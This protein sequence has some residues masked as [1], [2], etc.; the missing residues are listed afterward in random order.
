VNLQ[1]LEVVGEEELLDIHP[2]EWL[3]SPFKDVYEG[4]HLIACR[5]RL[6]LHG[7]EVFVGEDEVVAIEFNLFGVELQLESGSLGHA[8]VGDLHALLQVV[9]LLVPHEL[10]VHIALDYVDRHDLVLLDS[11]N[12]RGALPIEEERLQNSVR[13]LELPKLFR[14]ERILIH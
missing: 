4:D 9:G 5:E 12:V 7:L 11:E 13:D 2:G 3:A 6:V 14:D 10:G 8:E 1:K